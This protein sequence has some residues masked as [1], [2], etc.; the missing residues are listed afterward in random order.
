MKHSARF[1]S[2]VTLTLFLFSCET[3]ECCVPPPEGSELHGNWQFVRAFYGFTNT[4]VTATQAGYTERLTIDAGTKTLNRFKNDKLVETTKF[5][6]SNQNEL[7]VIT[8]ENSKEYSY[9]TVSSENN[10]MVLSL[11]QRAPV[12]AI[13]ADGGTYYYEKISE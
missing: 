3:K 6:I 10:K 9:F 12:G 5:S 1:L 8:F 13:L 2:V 4:T 7:K 11:Y